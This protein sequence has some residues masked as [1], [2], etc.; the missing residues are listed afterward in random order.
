MKRLQRLGLRLRVCYRVLFGNYWVFVR[1]TDY[2]V[3]YIGDFEIYV[4][5]YSDEEKTL[6]I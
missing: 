4:N 2:D 3:N 1:M 6:G 5:D